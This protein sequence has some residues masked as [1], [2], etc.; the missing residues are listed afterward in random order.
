MPN[1][2]LRQLLEKLHAEIGRSQAVDSES[3][4][5]LRHLEEDIRTLLTRTEKDQP[6]GLTGRLEEAI[7]KLEVSYPALT[8]MLSELLTILSNAGI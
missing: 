1:D 3:R 5:L 7:G 2:E 6:A 8:Q 4:E